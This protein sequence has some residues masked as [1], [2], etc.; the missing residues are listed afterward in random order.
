ME[1]LQV[2]LQ[3]LIGQ[4]SQPFKVILK[5]RL[6]DLNLLQDPDELTQR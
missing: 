4:Q 6:S 1:R 2:G 3:A 5:S